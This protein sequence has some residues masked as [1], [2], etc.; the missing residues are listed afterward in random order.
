[1]VPLIF[2]LLYLLNLFKTVTLRIWNA[3]LFKS[4]VY[5]IYN[6]AGLRNGTYKV[7]RRTKRS[8]C[9][10]GAIC[11]QNLPGHSRC[12]PLHSAKSLR[13]RHSPFGSAQKR[14]GNITESAGGRG[15]HPNMARALKSK[16][17]I[18]QKHVIKF[19]H[20]QRTAEQ[21]QFPG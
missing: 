13:G 8:T 2:K 17:I 3:L 14:E 15:F 5:I 9:N 20:L 11:L 19:V 10:W 1:M 18:C 4:P 12:T 6:T 7:P 21:K 16:Y